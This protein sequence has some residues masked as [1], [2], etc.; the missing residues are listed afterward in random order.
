MENKSDIKTFLVQDENGNEILAT[1]ITRMYIN[2]TNIKYLIYSIDDKNDT[3]DVPDSE[4]QVLILAAKIKTNEN[5]EEILENLSNEEE[6]KAVY[7]AFQKS[8]KE[9]I[10]K[11]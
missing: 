8:Y 7:D 6:R 1:E 2:D 11:K 9:A 3:R 4:K 5:G 10:G